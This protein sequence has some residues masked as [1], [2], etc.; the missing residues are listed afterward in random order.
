MGV[1]GRKGWLPDSSEGVRPLPGSGI[2]F[3]SPSRRL[4]WSIGTGGTFSRHV[5]GLLRADWPSIQQSGWGA[6]ASSPAVEISELPPVNADKYLA[7]GA[8]IPQALPDIPRECIIVNRCGLDIVVAQS[9]P[10]HSL[11]LVRIAIHQQPTKRICLPTA[12]ERPSISPSL[13]YR[14]CPDLGKILERQQLRPHK[15]IPSSVHHGQ[16]R[17]QLWTDGKSSSRSSKAKLP[18]IGPATLVHPRGISQAHHDQLGV[19]LSEDSGEG[20]VKI[21]LSCSN[22]SP[23]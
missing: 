7:V 21:A 1:S 2:F 6:C 22:R 13:S 9:Q 14:G 19:P 11:C 4:T 8:W 17:S 15:P 12:T 3:P 20:K 18:S 10:R 5:Q 23:A 16:P